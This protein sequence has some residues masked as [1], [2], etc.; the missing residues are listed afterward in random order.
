MY[1]PECSRTWH[2]QIPDSD[3]LG[4]HRV[5]SSLKK[6]LVVKERSTWEHGTLWCFNSLVPRNSIFYFFFYRYLLLSVICHCTTQRKKWRQCQ[7][8]KIYLAIFKKKTFYFVLRYRWLTITI[9]ASLMAQ[10]VKNLPAIWEIQ[11]GSLGSGRSPEEGNG[12]L[13]QYSCLENPM[14]RGAWWATVHGVAES[15]RTEQLTPS[16]S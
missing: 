7:L 2:L 6:T 9:G 12:N 15:D 16:L 14:D 8:T 10:M 3:F 13:L 5:G 1:Q 4:L 11:I